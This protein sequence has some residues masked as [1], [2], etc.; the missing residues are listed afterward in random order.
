MRSEV[1]DSSCRAFRDVRGP[2]TRPRCV[3]RGGEKY[4]D[5]Q[6]GMDVVEKTSFPSSWRVSIGE[7]RA[8]T[9]FVPK[10]V[11]LSKWIDCYIV[12]F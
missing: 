12:T 3:L 2:D 1:S 4:D 6:D 8:C 7:G 11:V 5:V 9:E 10:D